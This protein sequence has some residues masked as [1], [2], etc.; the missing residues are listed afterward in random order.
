M[1]ALALGFCGRVR[2]VK[3]HDIIANK[4]CHIVAAHCTDTNVIINVRVRYRVPAHWA[5]IAIALV[6]IAKINQPDLIS[7]TLNRFLRQARP[8][9]VRWRHVAQRPRKPNL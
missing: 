4:H 9:N 5:A 3:L 8:Y 6:N 2:R 1:A 7:K